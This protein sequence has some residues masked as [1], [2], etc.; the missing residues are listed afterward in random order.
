MKEILDLHVHTISSGHAY[1]TIKENI[2]EAKSKG[3]KII[4][5]SDHSQAMPGG[6]SNF[7]FLNL[8]ILKENIDGIRVLKGAEANILDFD[9]SVDLPERILNLLDYVIASIHI[10]CMKI[11]TIEENTNAI[12]NAMRNPFIKIIGHP[13]DSRISVDYEKIVLEA[14]KT[15]TLLEVNNS[16]LKT[17]AHRQG[18]RENLVT[19][20]KLCIKHD[21]M[22]IL[23]TDSHIYYEVGNF[24]NC[25]KV[26]QEVDF[27]DKLVLNYSENPIKILSEIKNI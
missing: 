23:G 19:M 24:D 20:L 14:K 21:V 2:E 6:A 7:H 16:S 4:G 13:D 1:S 8:K 22:V 15:G 12:I 9:G 25:I 10:P 3:L 11:G 26:L 18:A 17:D 5:I 27:P